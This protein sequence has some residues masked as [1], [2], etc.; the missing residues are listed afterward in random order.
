MKIE[1]HEGKLRVVDFNELD[2]YKIACKIEKDGAWFYNKLLGVVDAS[3]AKQVL[4]FLIEEEKKHLKFFEQCL[5]GARQSREDR[6]EEDDLL[7]S[8]NFGIFEPYQSIEELENMFPDSGKALK[9]GIIVEEKS[10]K[11]Y[12][13]CQGQVSSEET[14]REIAN[15]IEEEKKHKALLESLSS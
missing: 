5:S 4:T 15:I 12:E 9:L 10:I 1:E 2:A 3:A 7:S 14:R 13:A 6:F 11:F 8:M